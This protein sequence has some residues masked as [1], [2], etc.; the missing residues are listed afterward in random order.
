MYIKFIKNSFWCPV[1]SVWCPFCLKPPGQMCIC[2]H[3]ATC[4]TVFCNVILI[5]HLFLYGDISFLNLNWIRCCIMR[6]T[7]KENCNCLCHMFPLNSMTFLY[8]LTYLPLCHQ[9]FKIVMSEILRLLSS[10]GFKFNFNFFNKAGSC[11]QW[12]EPSG[13]IKSIFLNSWGTISFSRILLH[14]GE[15]SLSI[16]VHMPHTESSQVYHQWLCDLASCLFSACTVLIFV[17]C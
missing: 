8:L 5:I 11:E 6:I 17:V 15:K 2:N 10:S 4:G 14:V 1:C 12:N 7:W 9:V 13:S 3:H 16:A